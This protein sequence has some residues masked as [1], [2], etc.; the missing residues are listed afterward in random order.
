MM[1]KE[2]MYNWCIV[3]QFHFLSSSSLPYLL[4]LPPATPS[5]LSSFLHLLRVLFRA[6]RMCHLRIHKLER[7]DLIFCYG[8]EKNN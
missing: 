2:I 8:E 7:K 3:F 5:F 6:G 1:N 4:Y